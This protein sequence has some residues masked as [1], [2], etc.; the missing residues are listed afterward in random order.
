LSQW[1]ARNGLVRMI[2]RRPM[3]PLGHFSLIR[4]GRVAP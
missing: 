3:P 4:Y 1:A 2:E